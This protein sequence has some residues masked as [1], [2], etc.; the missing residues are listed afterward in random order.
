MIGPLEVRL[1]SGRSLRLQSDATNSEVQRMHLDGIGDWEAPT[2]AIFVP[3]ARRARTVIDVGAH[4]GMFALIA[5]A[6]NP[7]LHVYAFEPAPPIF[8]RLSANVR[9]NPQAKVTAIPAA[10][11]ESD[12]TT[13][14]YIPPGHLPTESSLYSGF[15]SGA[16]PVDV[17]TMRLDSFVE[18]HGIRNVDFMKIDAELYEASVIAG[19]MDL[20]R[21]DLPLIICEVLADV[22]ADVLHQ[23]LDPLGYRYFWITPGGLVPQ[24]RLQ[25]DRTY[26]DLNFLFVPESKLELLR[27]A[28]L[29]MAQ[30]APTA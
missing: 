13:K 26:H 30:T 11:S 4:T 24:E 5:A 21:R 14:L 8:A 12:G 10:A 3:L 15:R 28:A 18:K 9:A 7:S 25:G 23:H 1:P 17:E 16:V 29:P 6:E 19:A 2:L 22:N 20:I 27:E